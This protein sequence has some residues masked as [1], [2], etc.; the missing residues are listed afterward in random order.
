MDCE[1][2]AIIATLSTGP[3]G[4]GDGINMTNKTIINRI[5]R[6]DGI[7]LKPTNAITPIDSM[8]SSIYRPNYG[9]IW[10]T[11]SSINNVVFGYNILAIDV[12]PTKYKLLFDDLYPIPNNVSF[13]YYLFDDRNID[14]NGQC[15]NNTNIEKCGVLIF[16][17]SIDIQTSAPPQNNENHLH[18]WN[19][20]NFAMIQNNG[21]TLLGEMS[22]YSNISPQ[23]FKTIKL[24][25][26]GMTVVVKGAPNE[27]VIISFVTVKL[28]ILQI[29][30]TFN[31]NGDDETIAIS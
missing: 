25:N 5:V 8:F 1:M 31:N 6:K 18:S 4:I 27:V 2:E 10:M 20:Y 17:K 15:T 26:N 30:L 16:N 23:R 29:K 24:N 7:L 22:K 13:L 19:L 21:W 28:N 3:V 14:I 12:Y 11:Y 9:E